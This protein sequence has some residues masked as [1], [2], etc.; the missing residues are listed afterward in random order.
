MNNF[1][2]SDK[3]GSNVFWIPTISP[4]TT[5]N[6]EHPSIEASR[7]AFKR[8]F[9]QANLGTYEK[10]D[11]LREAPYMGDIF[12][13]LNIGFLAFPPLD[14]RRDSMKPEHIEYY[15]LFLNQLSNLPWLIKVKESEI[16]LFK[17]KQIQDKLFIVPNVWWVVGSYSLYK[18]ATKSSQLKLSK[19]SLIFEEEFRDLGK[20]IDEMPYANI[21]FNHKTELDLAASFIESK[22]LIFPADNLSHDPNATRWWKRTTAEFAD[23]KDFLKT[24]YEINNQD[25][26]LGGGWAVGEGSLSLKVKNGQFKK[27][28]ILLARVL[29]SN[30]SGSLSFYQQN[31]LIGEINT[32]NSED[33][34]RWFEVGALKEN[35]DITII[36]TG[37]INVINALV[38]VSSNNLQKYKARAQ[39]YKNRIFDFK[40][41]NTKKDSTVLN[42][43]Q[44][45]PTQYEVT[46]S[47]LTKPQMLLFAQNFDS[48]WKL[49]GVPP[50]P[51]YSMI[52]GFNI[53]KDGKYE[54]S[55]EPQKYVVTGLIISGLTLLGCLILLLV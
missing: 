6:A 35:T 45:S 40:E 11:F 52:N 39:S 3:N 47:G 25:F 54:L 17:V 13:V 32:K 5:L 46:I 31:I 12:D 38:L 50:F 15:E 22:D 14:P 30:Q 18:E 24:K 42:Y 48:S 37:N 41:A 2:K 44:I 4:L 34:I 43:R 26:D 16:P 49:N 53:D 8:P 29:E 36:A 19:N 9:A 28:S 20:R 21:I 1:I 27:G 55:F 51:V 7:L 10:F 33:N 23:W